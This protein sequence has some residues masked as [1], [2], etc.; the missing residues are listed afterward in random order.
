MDSKSE[1]VRDL[2]KNESIQA[3]IDN[4]LDTNGLDEWGGPKVE[5][6]KIGRPPGAGNRSRFHYL[7]EANPQMREALG[8]LVSTENVDEI[9]EDEEVVQQSD[10][11][12]TGSVA[13]GA[14][15]PA[16]A[17]NSFN[18]K[19]KLKNFIPLCD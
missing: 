14:Q 17:Q 7:W 1:R 6:A 9:K 2:W 15:V 11:P 4:Y 10:I 12:S 16:S 18:H 3:A 13:I 8:D 19:S 5:N